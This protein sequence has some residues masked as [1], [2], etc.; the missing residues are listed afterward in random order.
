MEENAAHIEREAT[1]AEL[2]VQFADLHVADIAEA[3]NQQPVEVAAATLALLARERAVEVLDQP[4]LDH[5]AELI[6][7]LP[8]D[9]AIALVSAMSADRQADTLRDLEPTVRQTFLARLDPE[10]RTSLQQLLA[11]PEN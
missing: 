7:A 9:Y 1:P 2:A 11:Y 5:G 3:L 8:I 10:T 4:E 6:E